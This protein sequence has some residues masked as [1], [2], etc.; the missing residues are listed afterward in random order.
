MAS[1]TALGTAMAQ[2]QVDIM[3]GIMQDNHHGATGS[4]RETD[5]FAS[6]GK[7]EALKKDRIYCI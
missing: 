5:A 3:H 2:R 4:G 7:E 6:E 1:E